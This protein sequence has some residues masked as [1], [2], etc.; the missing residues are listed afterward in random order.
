VVY[1]EAN[2]PL[3]GQTYS[4]QVYSVFHRV[5]EAAMQRPRPYLIAA[6]LLVAFAAL[7]GC[8]SGPKIRSDYNKNTD[9]SAY[10]TFGF[11]AQT[12]TDRGGY[13]TLVSSYFKDAVKREMSVRGYTFAADNPDLLVNFY[14]ESQEKTQVYS[15][16][17]ALSFGFRYGRPRFGYY[18]AWPFYPFYPYPYDNYYDAVQYTTGIIKVD[19]VDAKQQQTIWEARAE[20]RLTEKAEENPQPNIARLVNEVFR[21][22]PRGAAGT[23]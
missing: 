8:A 5:G 20:E 10:R 23:P 1:H 18:S 15:N 12:G 13:S 6:L 7:A 19:V 14:S 9:F 17:A 21:K 2:P 16:P 3:A 11:P 4:L 22:F